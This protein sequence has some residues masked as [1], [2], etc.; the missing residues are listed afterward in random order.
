M[1]GQ[2]ERGAAKN[3]NDVMRHSGH[4]LRD[5]SGETGLPHFQTDGK[6]GHTFYSAASATLGGIIVALEAHEQLDPFYIGSTACPA[7][8]C[9]TPEERAAAAEAFS[10]SPE[11]SGSQPQSTT[12][13][14]EQFNR[15]I[16]NDTIVGNR[17]TGR[18]DCGR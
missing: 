9:G 16:D 6:T 3:P 17:C 12:S 1:A 10:T 4:E 18:L 7:Y 11:N 13:K 5:G 2:I 15:F 14:P 8:E